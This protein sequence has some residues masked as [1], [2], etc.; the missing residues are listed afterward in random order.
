MY[1]CIHVWPNFS[2]CTAC[3]ELCMGTSTC[4]VA[5]SAH[6]WVYGVLIPAH[7]PLEPCTSHLEQANPTPQQSPLHINASSDYGRCRP[8]M[9]TSVLFFCWSNTT[10]QFP[11]LC[12]LIS[13]Y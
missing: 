8:A 3:I 1:A 11:L 6:L 2:I 7:S 13:G 10:L 12:Y 5:F 9:R 4:M